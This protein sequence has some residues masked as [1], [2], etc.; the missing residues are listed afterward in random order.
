M[1]VKVCVLSATQPFTLGLTLMDYYGKHQQPSQNF[2]MRGTTEVQSV[3]FK[4]S[5]TLAQNWRL[6]LRAQAFGGV[7]FDGFERVEWSNK[8]LSIFVQTDKAVYKPG[9]IVRFRSLVMHP[10]ISVAEDEPMDIV[11]KDPK[12]N[13]LVRYEGVKGDHMGVFQGE[14]ATSLHPP[15][16]DW[17]IRVTADGETLEKKFSVKEYELP[18]FEVSVKFPNYALVTDD[19][20]IG[21]I[22]A[23]YVFG[24]PLRGG[25]GTIAA[26]FKIWYRNPVPVLINFQLDQHGEATVNFTVKEIE[27]AAKKVY[28]WFR[29][30]YATLEFK[31]SVTDAAT[32]DVMSDE[33]SLRVYDYEAKV[34]F[35][36]QTPSA[37]KPEL[38]YTAYVE[39]LQP[40]GTPV[41]NLE[42]WTVSVVATGLMPY[43]YW[44]RIPGQSTTTRPPPLVLVNTTLTMDSKG[45]AQVTINSIP[46]NITYIS[47]RAYING[48]ATGYKY[49][50]R[51]TSNAKV[52]L[53]M[54]LKTAEPK[55]GKKVQVSLTSNA[56]FGDYILQVLS[57]GEV[58]ECRKI[59]RPKASKKAGFSFK[60]TPAM[61]PFL[62]VLAFFETMG[63]E[64]VADRKVLILDSFTDNEITLDFTHKEV[65]P[66][67][68]V[69]L[70]INADPGT[71]VF[72]LGVDR[73]V[74]LLGTGN[75]IT[76]NDVL[77]E[78]RKY[79][80][81]YF[82]FWRGTWYYYVY[83]T[84]VNS[85]FRN[86]KAGIITDGVIPGKYKDIPLAYRPTTA[87]PITKAPQTFRPVLLA[88]AMA[89]AT[90]APVR[91]MKDNAAAKAKPVAAPSTPAERLRKF[92]PETWLWM[93]VNIEHCGPK[94]LNLT[95]PDTITTWEVTAFG[96]QGRK[97]LTVARKPARLLTIKRLFVTLDLPY[98]AVRGETVC[99]KALTF[100]NYP[101][102]V[103]VSITLAENCSAF[104]SVFVKPDPY[105]PKDV[106]EVKESRTVTKQLG[107]LA[108][109]AMVVTTF[110]ISPVSLGDMPVQVTLQASRPAD[111]LVRT[112]RIKPE[113]VE[114]SQ[115][116]PVL[117]E[118]NSTGRCLTSVNLVLP[119]TIVPGSLWIC[120]QVVGDVLGG[121]IHNLG[122]LLAMPYGCGEQNMINFAPNT[123]IIFYLRATSRLTPEILSKAKQVMNK[124]YQGQLGY[125]R[126]DGSF[127]A[128][129]NRDKSGSTWLTAFVVKCFVQA[130]GLG[131]DVI[132]IEPNVVIRAV[133]WMRNHQNSD[134]SFSEPGRVIHRAMQGGSS[135]GVALAAYTA[136]A[137]KE[138]LTSFADQMTESTRNTVK[139]MLVK[140]VGYLERQV[141]VKWEK[142]DSYLACIVTYALVRSDSSKAARA[143]QLME[144]LAVTGGLLKYWEGPPPPSKPVTYSWYQKTYPMNVEMTSYALLAMMQNSSVTSGIPVVRWLHKQRNDKGG[145]LSTQDTV[146]G[147]E[148]LAAMSDLA[149]SDDFAPINVSVSWVSG[150][151]KIAH[152]TIDQSSVML[153]QKVFLPLVNDKA[154]PR[155]ISIGAM[156]DVPKGE[157]AFALAE[158]TATYHVDTSTV[159]QSF[160]IQATILK[161]T[162][163]SFVLHVC[164]SRA[165]GNTSSG[166]SM[167]V[168]EI[169][170]PSGHE[171]DRKLSA[172]G[173]SYRHDF[174]RDH[175]VLYFYDL[176]SEGTCIS[177]TMSMTSGVA[178]IQPAAI[179]LY[180]YYNRNDEMTEFYQVPDRGMCDVA[181]LGGACP[182]F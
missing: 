64:V 37:F 82:S 81:V 67:A 103:N 166:Q 145:F 75:D 40:D 69:G 102:A 5:S 47:M 66:G 104:Q 137:L 139:E 175:M 127:S 59:S 80:G 15:L 77:L 152:L 131:K 72:T 88:R 173:S 161:S 134:G 171:V 62:D 144:Q 163:T 172:Y 157:T 90:M 44:R 25:N 71:S 4:I 31:A 135:H 95:A 142:E 84:N 174:N 48:R 70:K 112:I 150:K 100:N 117:I 16:G 178:H 181:Q 89:M 6:Y 153:L 170:L 136:I 162:M 126:Y 92:F 121:V 169:Y 53:Q 18:R 124:G 108:P 114:R 57:K 87:A 26:N 33:T 10:D 116:Y 140:A 8:R 138:T 96:V 83:A 39:T 149:L 51:F 24:V 78:L 151:P 106:I 60:V 177:L 14:L 155:T 85:L 97:G 113:G 115:S 159:K 133:Y 99:F 23:K 42:N 38:S 36:R 13:L 61:A 160:Q 109:G 119:V 76:Q 130:A 29:L 11:I 43:Y 86:A 28:S 17:R 49:V 132:S 63:G 98:S 12:N 21:K 122:D 110:C 93:I 68:Q 65:K 179:L 91:A 32:G 168:S 74:K 19:F 50:R 176:D 129:G 154:Y 94:V 105:N 3:D 45:R 158:V 2:S 180:D 146:V 30:N 46:E 147:M 156:S 118:V 56:N 125:Q 143:L 35:T 27:A 1:K 148:A 41:V 167:I 58:V 79:S 165:K 107:M 128:F 20:I 101:T 34:T 164:L 111:G 73:S 7:T 52:F 9:E 141:P 54:K 123:F 120:V 182:E 55:I 22:K